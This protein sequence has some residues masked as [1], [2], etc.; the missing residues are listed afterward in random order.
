MPF[1]KKMLNRLFFRGKNDHDPERAVTMASDGFEPSSTIDHKP[2]VREKSPDR[3]NEL[4]YDLKES[5]IGHDEITERIQAGRVILFEQL[6]LI[7]KTLTL[8]EVA[9]RKIADIQTEREFSEFALHIFVPQILGLRE[10]SL[11]DDQTLSSFKLMLDKY[12]QLAR[13]KH[14][15]GY[16][17]QGKQE[18]EDKYKKTVAAL[19]NKVIALTEYQEKLKNKIRLLSELKHT[20]QRQEEEIVEL[21]GKLGS[22][23]II[24]HNLLED[25]PDQEKILA[26]N[27][28]LLQENFKIKKA[29]HDQHIQATDLVEKL[30]K[31]ESIDETLLN[32]LLNNLS[33]FDKL[34]DVDNEKQI[35]LSNK[36]NTGHDINEIEYRLSE[37]NELSRLAESRR[38]ILDGLSRYGQEDN[39]DDLSGQLEKEND[40][41]LNLLD[42]SKEMVETVENKGFPG[43][44][45]LRVLRELKSKATDFE[46]KYRSQV[47]LNEDL[48]SMNSKLIVENKEAI[49]M[50]NKF[51]HKIIDYENSIRFFEKN[52][53]EYFDVK[54]ELVSE[55]QKAQA[56][57]NQFD[58]LSKKYARIL[59]RYQEMVREYDS[60]FSQFGIRS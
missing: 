23:E 45:H 54:R 5:K 4:P 41:L 20:N 10:V 51:K 60:L 34:T 55:K 8:D 30:K 6:N 50:Y 24:F 59:N 29:L 19:K 2:N 15:P 11:L 27:M 33:L 21:E 58:N 38:S 35:I 12:V 22:L 3:D 17:L 9:R 43:F 42:A 39:A 32:R 36:A 7:R 47:K 14:T 31:N 46:E 48:L 40:Q 26:I 25:E 56:L 1:M 44:E 13:H 37:I 28:Q 57:K 18:D 52:Q 16:P 49:G 53:K